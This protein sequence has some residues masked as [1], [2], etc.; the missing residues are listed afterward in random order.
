MLLK[1]ETLRAIEAGSVTLAFRKWRRP[2]VREGGTLLTSIGQLAIEAVDQVTLDEITEVEAVAAGYSSL[3]LLRSQLSRRAEGRI[4]RIKLAMAGPDPRV[5]LRREIPSGEELE[6]IVRRLAGIDSRSGSG[7]WTGAI[8][9]TLRSR[10]GERAA[11]LARDSGMDR[12]DFK[13]NVRKL[14]GLGLTESLT[15]GYR[16]SPRGLAVLEHL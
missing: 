13:R 15:I 1:Q 4:Y 7:A 10:P 16:L 9:E 6:E 14:K 8:L 3:V 2:T 5:A 12:D 11:D